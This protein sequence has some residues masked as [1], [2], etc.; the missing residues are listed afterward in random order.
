MQASKTFGGNHTS[1]SGTPW[2]PLLVLALEVELV[3]ARD[4]R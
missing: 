2:G 3:L 1:K 4:S